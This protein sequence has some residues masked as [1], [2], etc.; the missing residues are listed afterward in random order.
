MHVKTFLTIFL[1]SSLVAFVVLT[2]LGLDDEPKVEWPESVSVEDA[3]RIR[4][5]LAKHDPRYLQDGDV[6][7]LA[8]TERDIN[9]LLHY[10]L[11][12]SPKTQNIRARASLAADA[13]AGLLQA[14]YP[15][16]NN[17]FGN[18]AN[19]TARL[20]QA[21]DTLELEW[22]RLGYLPVPEFAAKILM[23][24]AHQR[25]SQRSEEYNSIIEALQAL[26]AVTLH[27]DGLLLRY[28]WNRQLVESLHARGGGLAVTPEDRNRL[29][30]YTEFLPHVTP[31]T[32]DGA[33][34]TQVVQPFFDLARRR[35][36]EGNDPVAENRAAIMT[37]A[38]YIHNKYYDD[39]TGGGRALGNARPRPMRLVLVGRYDLA[40]H[41]LTSAGL[42]VAGGTEIADVVG[43]FKELDDSRGGSGF[44]FPDLAADRAGVRLAELATGSVSQARALQLRLSAATDEAAFMPSIDDLPEGLQ[45]LE[46]KERFGDTQSEAYRQV[47]GEIEKRLARCTAFKNL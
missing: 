16:P 36:E 8:L 6:R 25:L 7:Q 30:A 21:G 4:N 38:L 3:Q 35:T 2:R 28:E 44:S 11:T 22:M 31:L 27:A 29:K 24:A 19:I 33:T 23:A 20:Q 15:L 17:P 10:G 40:Q 43:L 12:R 34:L 41:F 45:D 5:E 46:F 37:L 14:S 26:K 47:K 9:L 13:G 1:L 18:Y 39:L 42:A 32:K